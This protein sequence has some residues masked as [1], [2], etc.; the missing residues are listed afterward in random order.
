MQLF[1]LKNYNVIFEPIT[2]MINEF[3]AI[4]DKNNDDNLTL[5]EISFIWFFTDVRSDF[6]NV[7]NEK[8][9]MAEIAHS[10]SLS[11]DWR[12]SKEVMD[13][14]DF[15]KQHSKT[16]SSGLYQ[17]SMISAQFLEKKL[18]RPEA[19]MEEL[20]G[21]GTPIYKLGDILNLIAKIPDVMEK[22]HK[23]RA[24]VIKELEAQSE[25]KGGKAKAMF[26]DG[27]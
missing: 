27:L 12:P 24:Q 10:I 5:K 23:A 3:K 9:R 8:E 20:D 22:L 4:K 6:Q 7:I 13:A 18:R 25:L 21:K 14:I 2:M 19:L 1:Q 26:E 16:P 15:Y 17:A 11:N